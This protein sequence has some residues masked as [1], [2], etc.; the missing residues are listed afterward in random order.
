MNSVSF[1]VLHKIWLQKIV[2]FSSTLEYSIFNNTSV[3]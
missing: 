1:L 2:E 3:T